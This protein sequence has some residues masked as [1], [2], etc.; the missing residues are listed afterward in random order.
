MYFQNFSCKHHLKEEQ[1]LFGKGSYRD[2]FECWKGGCTLNLEL[3]QGSAITTPIAI[4]CFVWGTHSL[5]GQ[6]GGAL[7]PLH[8]TS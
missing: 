6:S 4:E 2:T 5:V 3:K 1:L 8:L 7:T